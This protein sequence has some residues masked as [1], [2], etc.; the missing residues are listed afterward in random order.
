MDTMSGAE[1]K[2]V[3]DGLGLT[4]TWFAEYVGVASRTVARWFDG[5]DIPPRVVDIL[6]ALDMFTA[7]EVVQTC[8]QAR[9]SGDFVLKTYR[10]DDEA[11]GARSDYAMPASWFRLV[12]YRALDHLRSNGYTVRVEYAD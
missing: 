9:D 3:L 1:M 7:N 11:F 8:T 10:T 4:S 5:A 2:T 6:R 12:T